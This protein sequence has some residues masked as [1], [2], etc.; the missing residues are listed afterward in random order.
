MDESATCNECIGVLVDP[1]KLKCNHLFCLRCVERIYKIM[2]VLY[3]SSTFTCPQCDTITQLDTSKQ[4]TFESYRL[5]SPIQ[6]ESKVEQLHID[7]CALCNKASIKECLNCS[8]PFCEQC[9]NLHKANQRFQRHKLLSYEFMRDVKSPIML[10]QIKEITQKNYEKVT[11]RN[12]CTLHPGHELQLYCLK[13]KKFYCE[14]CAVDKKEPVV[15]ISNAIEVLKTK[16]DFDKVASTTTKLISMINTIEDILKTT[17]AN[18]EEKV[19]KVNEM[20]D[21]VIE[22]IEKK[23][24]EITTKIVNVIKEHQ[25]MLEQQISALQVLLEK[26]NQ[27]LYQRVA[28]DPITVIKL[29]ERS[30]NFLKIITPFKIN[31]NEPLNVLNT[32]EADINNIIASINSLETVNTPKQIVKLNS[33]SIANSLI[34]PLQE[35]SGAI[36]NLFPRLLLTNVLYR[37][38]THGSS[39]KVF[40]L[41]CDNKGPL[42]VLVKLKDESIFGGYTGKSWKSVG[43]WNK[44]TDAYLFRIA[45]SNTINPKKFPLKNGKRHAIYLG[46]KYGLVF[47]QG[48]LTINFDEMKKSKSVLGSVY[49]SFGEPFGLAGK[50]TDWDI[51]DIEV[52]SA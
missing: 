50:E 4:L 29:L 18:K 22:E 28:S 31:S 45:T 7:P 33:K 39:N 38:S 32:F 47:G 1:V 35:Q 15:S 52:F 10:E 11:V 46:G 25:S 40:H 20:C 17:E 8:L 9:A 49:E 43:G 37:V 6:K 44:S 5:N 36:I 2:N 34:L 3:K 13:S 23:R 30:D 26:G 16:A 48:D 24:L 27:I 41:H 21:K 42:F 12:T 14:L 19:K 51:L